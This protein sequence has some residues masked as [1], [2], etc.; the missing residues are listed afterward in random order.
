MRHLHHQ[1]PYQLRQTAVVLQDLR[2]S[3]RCRATVAPVK[4][5]REVNEVSEDDGFIVPASFHILL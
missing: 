2:S 3:P 4:R 1:R 5:S